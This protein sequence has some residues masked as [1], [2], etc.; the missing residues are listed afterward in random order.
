MFNSRNLIIL[1]FISVYLIW[2]S[3]YVLMK[4]ATIELHPFAVIF[5]QNFVASLVLITF[6][7]KKDIFSYLVQNI[8]SIASQ[9]FLML[10]CGV[11]FITIAVSKVSPALASIIISSVPLWVA[12][13]DMY[14]RKGINKTKLGGIILGLFGIYLL[15]SSEHTPSSLGYILL[16][17]V[18]SLSW[19]IGVVRSRK[20]KTLTDPYLTSIGQLL[21]ASIAYLIFFLATNSFNELI[22]NQPQTI[23]AVTGLGILG[24]ALAFT[25]F[26]WLLKNVN[27]IMVSTYAYINPIVSIL[28]S[29][30]LFGEA[31]IGIK[32]LYIGLILFSVFITVSAKEKEP[33][34]E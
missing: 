24:D 6:N 4:I 20:L 12:L 23:Y 33:V 17:L 16:L 29:W 7:F 30:I 26:I 5:W 28:L 32:V 14:Q 1:N 18:A 11:G 27:P 10:I 15:T 2:G 8:G 9:S 22:P 13:L 31:F 34:Y 3:T 19:S 25:S 21:L